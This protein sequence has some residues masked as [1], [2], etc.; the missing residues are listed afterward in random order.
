M[1][2]FHHVLTKFQV[3][4]RNSSWFLVLLACLCWFIR[5]LTLLVV[6]L[7]S[8]QNLSS[9][10]RALGKSL[11]LQQTSSST[12]KSSS[13]RVN[14][15]SISSSIFFCCSTNSLNRFWEISWVSVSVSIRLPEEQISPSE[16][17]IKQITV[18]IHIGTFQIKK[19][20]KINMIINSDHY[21]NNY[22]AIPW[23]RFEV[24][25]KIWTE[26]K[27]SVNHYFP[28]FITTWSCTGLFYTN[29]Y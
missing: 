29:F 20:I 7:Q 24:L 4:T 21:C 12:L 26:V 18:L 8:F 5:E 10:A 1:H 2:N 23:T 14:F 9:I 15:A 25:L 19:I 22:K 11:V 3:I 28:Q 13:C 6:F 27:K 17:C 16:M